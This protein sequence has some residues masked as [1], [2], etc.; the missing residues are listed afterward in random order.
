[1]HRVIEDLRTRFASDGFADLT[2]AIPASWRAI[3]AREVIAALDAH[4]VRRDVRIAVTG[5]SPRRYSIADRDTLAVA[6]PESARIYRS[7]ELGELVA[8]VAGEAIDPVPYEPEEFIATRLHRAGDTHGWHWD[9]YGYALVWVL[10][11]PH[12]AGGGVLEYLTNVPWNKHDPRI[13]ERLLERQPQRAEL[14]AGI[15]Y[16]LRTDTTLH[17]VTPLACEGVRDVACF[18]YAARRTLGRAV[19]HETLDVR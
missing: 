2:T 19:S 6:A 10:Q 13:E 9:D 16:L 18:S 5:D 15:V 1:M 12:P 8:A 4:A 14:A 7:T 11:A 17:R 3:V